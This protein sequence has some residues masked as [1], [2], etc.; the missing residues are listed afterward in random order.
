VEYIAEDRTQESLD[1]Y[2]AG[3]TQ[4]QLDGLE[5][6]AMDMWEPYIQA[7]QAKVPEAAEKIVF[8]PLPR[9]GSHR[10]GGRHGPQTRTPRVAGVGRRDA[11]GQQVPVVVQPWKCAGAT[12]R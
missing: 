7:T 9:Q 12:A 3:L 10:Q 2:Y 6:V 5:A 8:R 11:Q 4:E 1:G